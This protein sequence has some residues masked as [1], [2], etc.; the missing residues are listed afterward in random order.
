MKTLIET[1]KEMPSSLNDALRLMET[2]AMHLQA[3]KDA[4]AQWKYAENWGEADEL[5]NAR[6]SRRDALSNYSSFGEP[7]PIVQSYERSI[8]PR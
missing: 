2:A 7:L 4:L 6:I 3:M 5:E 1:L 8:D